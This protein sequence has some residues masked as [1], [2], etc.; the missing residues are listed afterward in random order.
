MNSLF[1]FSLILILGSSS[2]KQ[3]ITGTWSV[4]E[5]NTEVEISRSGD[6]YHG[7]IVKSDK[8]K[9]IGKEILRDLKEKD[10][11]YIG[12]LYAI[13]KDRLV[14]VVITP[15]GDQL[16]LKVS[17]GIASKIIHWTKVK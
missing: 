17:A 12:K 11:K 3:E 7:V 2:Q 15:N 10:G 14:D 5:D 13:K 1:I 9:A 6:T 16:D 4:P 8:E